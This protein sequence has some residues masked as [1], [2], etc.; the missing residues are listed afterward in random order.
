MVKFKIS[1]V[2]FCAAAGV[3]A[4]AVT[5]WTGANGTEMVV[6]GD[7][8]N[9]ADTGGT[10]GLGS[11]AY[12]YSI[13]KYEVTNTQFSKFLN[14]VG[15]EAVG[16]YWLYCGFYEN[17]AGIELK[18]GA[19]TAIFGCENKAVSYVSAYAAAMYCNWLGNGATSTSAFLTGAY[20]F[21]NGTSVSV[22]MNVAE[23]AKY[24]L[25][26]ENEWYK[27]AY[28]DPITDDG[29][30]WYYPTQ[31]KELSDSTANYDYGSNEIKDVGSYDA[32][33]AY[34]TYDQGGNV[35]EWCL[36]DGATKEI[37]IRGGSFDE[38]TY[39]LSSECNLSKCNPDVTQVDIGFRI[40]SLLTEAISDPV[41]SM[42]EPAAFSLL[43]GAFALALCASRRR[44]RR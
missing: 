30:Y 40:V 35:E 7:A 16:T 39:T 23:D 11:V 44:R 29:K 24:R 28:Y 18:N 9:A 38:E 15:G 3:P 20:D 1:L 10:V 43:A 37:R 8:G 41:P 26:T 12:E 6:V 22:L 21:T 5:S 32:P 4:F 42:P 34:G 31:S 33:T 13:G 36:Q 27:A 19:Y 25:P 17:A 2:L 14:A